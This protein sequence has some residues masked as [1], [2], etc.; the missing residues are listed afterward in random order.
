V[1]LSL[2][3]SHG[4]RLSANQEVEYSWIL[5]LVAIV[6]GVAAMGATVHRSSAGELG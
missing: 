3:A 1:L 5:F 6:V 4:G 2:I